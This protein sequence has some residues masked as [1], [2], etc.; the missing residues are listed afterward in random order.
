MCELVLPIS[1]EEEIIVVAQQ[2][3][4]EQYPFPSPWIQ[5]VTNASGYAFT[6][7]W[8]IRPP[9]GQKKRKEVELSMHMEEIK[10]CIR[11]KHL[12]KKDS[13]ETSY[14]KPGH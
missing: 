7:K 13:R 12:V 14:G 4:L 8:E 2:Q 6:V 3:L 1:I 11:T 10:R 9:S 5:P